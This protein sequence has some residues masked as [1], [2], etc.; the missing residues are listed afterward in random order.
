VQNFI[1][2]NPKESL[3]AQLSLAQVH[4]NASNVKQTIETL[5]SI[6][7]LHTKPAIAA[8]L[9]QLYTQI[10][11]ID[12]AI[13][14]LDHFLSSFENQ[15][16]TKDK[17]KAKQVADFFFFSFRSSVCVFSKGTTKSM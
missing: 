5:N 10:N 4:L 12:L 13:K 3:K 16:A 9:V 2:K 17:I 7:A 1:E 14:T 15:K 11:E 6:P 8:S